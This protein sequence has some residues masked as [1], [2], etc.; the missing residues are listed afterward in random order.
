MADRLALIIAVDQYQDPTIPAAAH[1]GAA[2][3][4]VSRALEAL[5]FN[6]EPQILLTGSGAPR[7]AVSS[8]LRKLV[9][10]PPQV[11]SLFVFFAGHAFR[12]GKEDYLA[13]FDS[14]ADDL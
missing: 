8:R 1:A 6:K 5:G 2:P 12:E 3:A 11:E 9:K 10:S 13:C 14:Q 4:A 7:T